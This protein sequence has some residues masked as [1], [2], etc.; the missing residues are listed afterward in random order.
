MVAAFRQDMLASATDCMLLSLVYRQN[1]GHHAR[2]TRGG[3]GGASQRTTVELA[4]VGAE[5]AAGESEREMRE[6]GWQSKRERER[7]GGRGSEREGVRRWGCGSWQLSPC[8]GCRA[9]REPRRSLSAAQ[10]RISSAHL[11]GSRTLGLHITYSR[12][13]LH[14][15]ATAALSSLRMPGQATETCPGDGQ[16]S[17]TP[18]GHLLHEP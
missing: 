18:L 8:P 12:L 17:G 14:L 7:W 3:N 5:A 15:P 2:R 11:S 10:L 9:P 4:P 13:P 6:R 1:N 16:H